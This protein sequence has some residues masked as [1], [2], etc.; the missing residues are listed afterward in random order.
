MTRTSGCVI[1]NDGVRLHYNEAGAGKAVLL[2]HGGGLSNVWWDRNLETLSHQF[3]VIAPDTRG[4]GLSQR[5]PWGHRTAR[6]AADVRDIIH[7]LGLYNVTL[8]GWSIGARTCFSYLELFGAC[9][10]RG[11][12]LVDETVHITVHK[13]PDLGSEQQLGESNR[14]HRRRMMRT[15]LG[16]V[17]G[18]RAT[19]AE[20]DRLAESAS[21]YAPAS[22]TLGADYKAQDWRPLCPTI[23]VP[24]LVTTGLHSGAF[25]GCQYAA[26]HI[27]GA[28]LEIFE[29]SNHG[30][31]YSEAKKFNRVVA[32]FVNEPHLKCPELHMSTSVEDAHHLSADRDTAD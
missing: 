10:L 20:I 21:G 2:I 29:D 13:Q 16:P 12:V 18:P 11:V 27:P 30:L 7:A 1:A 14:D 31:F 8:V 22:E 28:R 19:Y 23:N 4:C 6:Y 3:H 17:Y 24:V 5:T 32:D 15:M 25:P 9:R 26:K